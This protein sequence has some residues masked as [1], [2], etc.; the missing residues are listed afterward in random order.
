MVTLEEIE[1]TEAQEVLVAVITIP[2]VITKAIKL[3]GINLQ[4][5][6]HHL[7][8]DLLEVQEVIQPLLEALVVIQLLLEAALIEA[9]QVAG[10]QE[11]DADKFNQLY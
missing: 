11:V 9:L 10:V 2:E 6:H 4:D 5:H 3:V 7:L 8:K 1:L